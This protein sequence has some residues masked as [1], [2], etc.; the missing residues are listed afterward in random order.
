MVIP[1]KSYG[2]QV[3]VQAPLGNELVK[4]YAADQRLPQLA[5]AD[6]GN[7]FRSIEYDTSAIQKHYRD[8]AKDSGASLVE[9]ILSLQ[10]VE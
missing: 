6:V 1:D 9:D 5:G 2:F 7:G 3:E 4:I 10:T 8:F